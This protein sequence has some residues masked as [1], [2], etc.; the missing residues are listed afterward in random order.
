M[1]IVST[2]PDKKF[3]LLNLFLDEIILLEKNI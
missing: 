2:L 3:S 1:K